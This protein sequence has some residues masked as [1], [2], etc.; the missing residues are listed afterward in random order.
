MSSVSETKTPFSFPLIAL[1]PNSDGV[2]SLE[3]YWIR[4]ETAISCDLRRLGIKSPFL[5]DCELYITNIIASFC[6]D[7]KIVLLC[8]DCDV[9]N[10]G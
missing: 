6:S 8:Y 5:D 9:K 3:K 10:I 4:R 2:E 1:I 7:L